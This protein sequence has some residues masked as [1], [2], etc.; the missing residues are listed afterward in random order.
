M[1]ADGSVYY[2]RYG[3]PATR[4]R[5]AGSAAAQ[6]WRLDGAG[7]RSEVANNSFQHL[8]PVQAPAGGGIL[9]VTVGE[10]TPSSSPMNAPIGRITDSP[11]RTP[12]VWRISGTSRSQV[13]RFSGS[14]VRFLAAARAADRIA[15]EKDG[16]VHVGSVNGP[17]QPVE[18]TAVID[19][20][21]TTVT[22]SIETTGASQ[23]SISPDGSKAA[24]V[25]GNEIWLADVKPGKRPN[26]KDAVR[27]TD[28]AGLD[29]NPLWTPD[30]SAL[31]F[32]SDREGSARIYRWYVETQTIEAVTERSQSA[33]RYYI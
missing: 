4:P 2:T 14:P 11:S 10:Q 29:S 22:R 5:Y 33:C 31:L 8:W 9:T 7:R 6:I 16:K 17:H 24:F 26:D 21:F 18:I 32:V 1:A 13:T 27:V 23:P 20:Q 12:N 3:F 15:F 25:A 19:D 30:G 28:W